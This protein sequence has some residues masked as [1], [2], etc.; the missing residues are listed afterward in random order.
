MNNN[1]TTKELPLTG[2]VR[3]A[4]FKGVIPLS[5]TTIWKMVKQGRFPQPLKVSPSLRL[6]NA[7]ALHEWMRVGP[8][9][10]LAAHPIEGGEPG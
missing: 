9:A 10:W 3:R 2:L 1:S 4:Q 5:D 7:P 6:W 8:D